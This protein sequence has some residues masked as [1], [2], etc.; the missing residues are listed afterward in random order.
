MQS[1]TSSAE[2]GA[3]GIVGAFEG[4]DL[5]GV[6]ANAMAGLTAGILA[7]GASAVAAAQSIA[8]QITGA[9]ANALQIHSPSR[10]MFQMGE[11]VTEGFTLGMNAGEGDVAEA[12]SG[13]A[14]AVE[15]GAGG[16]LSGALRGLGGAG[17][18]TGGG[19]SVSFSPVINIQGNASEADVRSALSWGME[20]FE[21]L[22]NRLM[23]ERRREAFA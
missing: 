21:R 20:E 7:E 2:A 3:A 8:S 15:T 11:Y 22:Y 10:V 5:S 6:A 4:M 23:W 18:A 14:R 9:M 17:A 19:S 13:I 1:A 12:S 16:S